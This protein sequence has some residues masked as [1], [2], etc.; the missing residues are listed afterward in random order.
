MAY[1]CSC[2]IAD[3]FLSP[4]LAITSVVFDVHV[5]RCTMIRRPGQC[6][7]VSRSA[8]GCF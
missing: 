8:V 5:Y 7:M 4:L 1:M 3:K 6:V 2:V